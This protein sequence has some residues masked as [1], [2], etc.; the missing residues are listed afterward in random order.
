VI[1]KI[2]KLLAKAEGASTAA[3]AE[4]YMAKAQELATA[5]SISLAVA[6]AAALDSRRREEPIHRRVSVGEARKHV[7]KHLIMLFHG[8]ASA[9]NV[10]CDIAHNNTYVIAYGFPADIAATEQMWATLSVVMVRL[11]DEYM[12]RGDWRNEKVW[13]QVRAADPWTRLGFSL[14]DEYVSVTAQAARA[15][16]Y[17]GFTSRIATRLAEAHRE[18]VK[19]AVD[20]EKAAGS[21]TTV[22]GTEVAMRDKA[23][24][25]QSYHRT[26]S[27][28][29]GSWK[30]DQRRSG[31]ARESRAAGSQAASSVSL[32]GGGSLGGARKAVGA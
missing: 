26:H 31:T 28:A 29:R 19:T 30:G 18:A 27:R 8:I 25:V 17:E 1:E 24:E 9:N 13:R 23:L 5:Y 4:A 3:E 7:N 2:A 20:A 11:A 10:N 6:R 22:T 21:T 32:G 15:S 14:R 12:K 16:W